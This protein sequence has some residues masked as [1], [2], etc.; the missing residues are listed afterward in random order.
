MVSTGVAFWGACIQAI[1]GFACVTLL[2]YFVYNL[3]KILLSGIMPSMATMSLDYYE[4]TAENVGIVSLLLGFISF[5][6]YV[7]YFIGI[8]LFKGAQRSVDSGIRVRNIILAELTM[9]A[10]FILYILLLYIDSDTFLEY[11]VWWPV[12]AC[13]LVIVTTI[14]LLVQFRFLS[15]ETTWSDTS[16]NGADNVS[17]SYGYIL[18]MVIALIVEFL[19]IFMTVRTYASRFSMLANQSYGMNEM[20]G[21]IQSVSYNIEHFVNAVK[22]ESIAVIFT[23]FILSVLVTVYRIIGWNRIRKGGRE[24][25]RRQSS[26]TGASRPYSGPGRFC[27]KCGIELPDTSLF[28]PGCG[29]P[30]ASTA[31]SGGTAGEEIPETEMSDSLGAEG[32]SQ[33]A[34]YDELYE[35]EESD[36]RRK[37]WLWGSVAAGIIA[38]TAGVWA[39]CSHKGSIDPNAYVLPDHTVL[40]RSVEDGVGVDPIGELEY[41]TPVEYRSSEFDKE[42]VWVKASVMKGGKAETGYMAKCDL[43]S[44]ED[45]DILEKGGMSESELRKYMPFNAERIALIYALKNSE[46]NWKLDVLD[47]DEDRVPNS[48]KLTVSGAS[49]SEDCVGLILR[50]KENGDRMFFLYSTP[51]IYSQGN[52]RDPVYLYNEP[53]KGEALGVSDVTFRKKGKKYTVS[54]TKP[55]DDS[56]YVY[57]EVVEK[58]PAS[59]APQ[60][61]GM[62]ELSGYIDGKYA[63]KMTIWEDWDGSISGNYRYL[64]NE[65]YIHLSGEY[66]DRGGR[67]DISLEENVNGNVTGNFRGSYDGYVFSGS[68]TSA[69]GSREL[70]FRLER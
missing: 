55:Q 46:G 43:I 7:V 54:Y 69:D 38:I 5:L 26:V 59:Q 27:H 28:C 64:N 51:D 34:E 19:I 20:V 48:R 53:V 4:H 14:V 23:V 10:V 8:C 50:N 36:S 24:E 6:G 44:P 9:P 30:V 37:W 62:L 61:G 25:V 21:G 65:G 41:G 58:L 52:M 3:P 29:T 70:P 12:V 49:P 57:E 22:W 16:R 68:W 35:Y 60:F 63:V 1:F 66:I 13:I 33:T 18:W 45:F 56:D 2:L 67:H 17:S 15:K 31:A 42:G 11:Y 47:M 39:I 32:E 40:F